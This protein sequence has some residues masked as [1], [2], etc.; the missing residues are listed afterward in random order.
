MYT[1]PQ[2]GP[3]EVRHACAG[4]AG[5]IARLQIDSSRVGYQ[6]ILARDRLD[7]MDL[8]RRESVWLHRMATDVFGAILVA[9]CDRTPIGYCALLTPTLDADA[10]EGV[11]GLSSIYVDPLNWRIGCGT[12]LVEAACAWLRGRGG[13]S[14]LTLWVFEANEGA[15]AFYARMGFVADGSRQTLDS[16]GVPEIRMR[17][18]I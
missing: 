7:A 16:L 1:E 18:S 4:D 15:R 8:S 5:V 13:W 3:I 9:E 2:A 14:A 17:L 11:A 10:T 6:G 12:A